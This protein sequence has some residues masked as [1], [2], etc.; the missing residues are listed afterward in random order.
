MCDKPKVE[1]WNGLHP[2]IDDK[3]PI[4]IA[5]WTADG[6]GV[7]H[8]PESIE[9]HPAPV[10]L[11]HFAFWLINEKLEALMGEFPEW[12]KEFE[13]HLGKLMVAHEKVQN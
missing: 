5:Y 12:R 6:S 3:D 2:L 11:A 8:S 7:S 4:A 10:Y 9:E 13:D 1:E